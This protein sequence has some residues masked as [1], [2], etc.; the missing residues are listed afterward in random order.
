[1]GD[2]A[3]ESGRGVDARGYWHRALTIYRDLDAPQAE[4]VAAR[5]A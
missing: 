2:L 4:E 1:L 3:Y 5:L